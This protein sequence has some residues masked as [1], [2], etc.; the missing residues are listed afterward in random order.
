MA[1]TTVVDPAAS[2]A[3]SRSVCKNQLTPLFTDDVDF[4]LYGAITIDS[5]LVAAEYFCI[6]TVKFL[7]ALAFQT[8]HVD[9]RENQAHT[10]VWFQFIGNAT[11]W[12]S[13]NTTLG[14]LAPYLVYR[15]DPPVQASFI[16][17]LE[18]NHRNLIKKARLYVS[19][20]I[21]VLGL[22]K[23]YFGDSVFRPVPGVPNA[24]VSF[25]VKQKD[26]CGPTAGNIGYGDPN[27]PNFL[28]KCLGILAAQP[29]AW[30]APASPI[31]QANNFQCRSGHASMAYVDPVTHCPHV[32]MNSTFCIL[33]PII[34]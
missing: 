14:P 27:D 17:L 21:A 29:P 6:T 31:L 30:F 5:G 4:E 28:Q 12:K 18:F 24:F 23:L 32:A 19:D 2:N 33:P 16:G 9:I 10:G 22:S 26:A 7:A 3:T 11:F 13:L 15:P 20:I 8:I 25:C 1:E 34:L